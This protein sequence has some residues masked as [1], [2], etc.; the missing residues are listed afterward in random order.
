[1]FCKNCG[2]ELPDNSTFCK[3]CG[4]KQAAKTIKQ[5][6]RAEMHNKWNV[7]C[8]VAPFIS[9]VSFFSAFVS[10]ESLAG[11]IVSVISSIGV[12]QAILNREKGAL[13]GVLGFIAGAIMVIIAGIQGSSIL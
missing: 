4:E 2:K 10:A 3:F 8:V 13:L 1:M 12:A 9:V 5:N 6:Q 7:F 11:L